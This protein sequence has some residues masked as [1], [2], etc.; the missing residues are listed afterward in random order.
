[1]K[2]VKTK[3]TSEQLRLIDRCLGIVKHQCDSHPYYKPT[4]KKINKIQRII[5]LNLI[6]GGSNA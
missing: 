1:M 4:V 3:L 6:K 5:Q 2:E